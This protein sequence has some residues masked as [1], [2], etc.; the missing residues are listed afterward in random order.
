MYLLRGGANLIKVRFEFIALKN[1][2]RLVLAENSDTRVV[3]RDILVVC[4]ALQCLERVNDE[5]LEVSCFDAGKVL[6][7]VSLGRLCT[8]SN[9][10]SLVLVEVTAGACLVQMRAITVKTGH[11][12]SNTVGA[13]PRCLCASLV[14]ICDIRD[15]AT[16]DDRAIKLKAM[17]QAFSTHV[18]SERASISSQSCNTNTN[19]IIN[20]KKLLLVRRE[21]LLGPVK[22]KEADSQSNS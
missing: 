4:W 9:G 10:H 22:Q 14:L 8:R 11:K 12:K 1:R 15:K 7:H 19:M 20:L 2:E 17:V 3:H 18:C 13:L 16:S 21:L 6:L 5:S